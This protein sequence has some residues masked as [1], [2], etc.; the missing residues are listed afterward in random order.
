MP[1]ELLIACLKRFDAYIGKAAERKVALPFDRCSA[2][3]TVKSVIV[4]GN[5]K[6]LFSS[7]NMKSEIQ[8]MDTRVIASAKMR[9]RSAHKKQTI[10]LIE[11]DLS[12]IY[13]M[14]ILCNMGTF[15]FVWAELSG[16]VI[17]QSYSLTKVYPAT[18]QVESVTNLELR[19]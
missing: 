6:T 1:R 15:K 11:E 16:D 3:G 8:P 4:L 19:L 7:P 18:V 2:H 5:V 10:G 9:Y 12:K 14:V 13:R 17:K